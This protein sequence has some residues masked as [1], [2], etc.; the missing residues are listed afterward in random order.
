MQVLLNE[1]Q[2]SA[3]KIHV[4]LS[5]VYSVCIRLNPVVTPISASKQGS[6]DPE[7]DWVKARLK[8]VTQLAIWLDTLI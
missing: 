4:G 8:W 3:G 6:N 7:S 2:I 1:H 5:S